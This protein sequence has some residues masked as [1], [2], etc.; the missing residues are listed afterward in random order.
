MRIL[1]VSLVPH[2]LPACDAVASVAVLSQTL[3]GSTGHVQLC[4]ESVQLLFRSQ[5]LRSGCKDT[6]SFYDIK[7]LD[8]LSSHE[9]GRPGSLVVEETLSCVRGILRSVL[10][11][12]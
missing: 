11:V 6:S 9:L 5:D 2:V 7:A 3:N 10:K 4:Q 8:N 12:K 1:Y